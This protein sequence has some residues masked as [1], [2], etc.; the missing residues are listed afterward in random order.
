MVQNLAAERQSLGWLPQ[1]PTVLNL[2]LSFSSVNAISYSPFEDQ[3]SHVE[4]SAQDTLPRQLVWLLM[5]CPGLEEVFIEPLPLV[6][7]SG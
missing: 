7:A 6:Q 5:V 2:S 1:S 3:G 4:C